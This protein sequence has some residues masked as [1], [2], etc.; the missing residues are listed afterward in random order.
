MSI[1]A[2]KSDGSAMLMEKL[3]AATVA[4]D[5]RLP[6]DPMSS[7]HLSGVVPRWLTP[8]AHHMAFST[9]YLTFTHPVLEIPILG[10]QPSFTLLR[11]VRLSVNIVLTIY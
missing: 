6:K 8:R 10:R 11:L 9:K 3:D 1:S 4:A 5:A 7:K 2:S